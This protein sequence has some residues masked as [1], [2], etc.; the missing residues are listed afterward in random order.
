[1]AAIE[2]WLYHSTKMDELAVLFTIPMLV[3]ERASSGRILSLSWSICP[4]S[5]I[6]PWKMA[7]KS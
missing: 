5:R 3:P 1:M 2:K 7:K 6:E 4:D